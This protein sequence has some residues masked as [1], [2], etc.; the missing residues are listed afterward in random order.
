MSN[1]CAT[2]QRISQ[3]LP[4]PNADKLEIAEILG[5]RCVVKKGEFKEGD[6]V[7]YI[8]IDSIVPER[9]E[10]AFL[11]GHNRIKTIRLRQEISQGLV[12]PLSILSNVTVPISIL[13]HEVGT[14][15]S[16]ILGITHYEKPIPAQLMGEIKGN[17]PT[18]LVPK[19]DEERIQNVPEILN[20]LNGRECVATEKQNGTSSTFIWDGV[21]FW[22]CSRNIAKKPGTDVY[23]QMAEKYKLEVVLKDA[24]EWYFVKTGDR[25]KFAIQG[26]I[27]GPGLQSNQ[28]G[29][30]EVKLLVFD[31]YNIS[32]GRYL[33]YHSMKSFCDYYKLE[34]VPTLSIFTFGPS[35]H[36]MEFLLEMAKGNYEGTKNKREGIVIR[37]IEN[38]YSQIL[39]GRVSFKVLNTDFLLEH[40]E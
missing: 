39:R 16:E 24:E 23:S 19:T 35:V 32:T 34:T 26:E 29:F 1:N 8:Q 38:F 6:L 4:H 21:E 28:M 12:M 15:V 7:V 33:D 27:C 22:I 17:F 9:E 31:V 25:N 5:W 11:G 14:D 36:T 20:E 3:I 2:I 18:H 40:G 30:S 37:P 10:F 13:N